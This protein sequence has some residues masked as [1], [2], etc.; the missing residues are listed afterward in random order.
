M[1]LAKI[2]LVPLQSG[3]ATASAASFFASSWYF[4][5]AQ[6]RHRLLGDD[7]RLSSTESAS[8]W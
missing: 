5:G 2:A 4:S 8:W 7:R 1:L 6:G 3:W